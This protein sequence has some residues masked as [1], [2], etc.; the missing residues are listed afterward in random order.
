MELN[1]ADKKILLIEDNPFMRKSIRSM[2]QT[3]EA[4]HIVESSDANKALNILRK[5]QFDIILADYNLGKGKNSLQL[6][7]ELRLLKLL[8]F[9]TIF[10]IISSEQSP[11][12]VLGAMD[13]KPDEY[14][15]KPF[16][17]HQ[18]AI[19]LK[20]NFLL[21]QLLH[22][23]NQA[24][25]ENNYAAAIA[26]CDRLLH[27]NSQKNH[28]ILLRKRAELA[29]DINDLEQAKTIYQQILQQRDLPWARLGLAIISYR[30]GQI[31]EA[32]NLF[33]AIITQTPL[34][35]ECYDWLSQIYLLQNQL[36]KAEEILN[37]AVELSPT[38]ILRQKKLGLTAYRNQ[39]LERA[40]KALKNVLSLS[41]NSI[42]KSSQ[43]YASLATIYRENQKLPEAFALLQDLRQAFLY[44]SEAELRALLLESEL[45]LSQKE[46]K[47][48]GEKLGKALEIYQNSLEKIPKD[49]RLE[50]AKVCFLHH[51]NKQANT[52]LSA[53]LQDHFDDPTFIEEIN[54]MYR[55]IGQKN[56]TDKIIRAL[57]T[58]LIELN[59]QGV[60]LFEQGKTD[61][62]LV[63]FENAFQ[64]MPRNKTIL[65]NILK[66]QLYRFKTENTQELTQQIK[67]LLHQA[68]HLGV[69]KEKIGELQM[70]FNQLQT[71]HVH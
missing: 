32:I 12:M 25:S 22:P 35:I 5:R 15:T 61:Q 57:K 18:L 45:H 17:T 16:N 66:I 13:G 23:I 63:L 34:F 59:N 37:Q 64:K 68:E 28:L 53:L 44:D 60:A 42:H 71:S 46:L 29:L 38:S 52:I 6:L 40:E 9:Q 26:H 47:P 19:R 11:Q 2:L 24:I 14:L 49:A 43:D 39:H 30:S 33:K 56:L 10:I 54:Q 62:A 4:E 20:R 55:K 51:K 58:D 41:K 50:L 70:E 3:L 21:K 69:A 8:H 7:E 31:D 67:S 48:A 27:T 1:L 65:L 36:D